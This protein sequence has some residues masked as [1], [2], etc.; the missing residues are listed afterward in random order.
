MS[1]GG[2]FNVITKDSKVSEL[3]EHNNMYVTAEMVQKHLK[4]AFD[5]ISF[6]KL[7]AMSFDEEIYCFAKQSYEKTNL[8]PMRECYS[9]LAIGI[10]I[11]DILVSE[12]TRHPAPLQNLDYFIQNNC[13][14]P[15]D[16]CNQVNI[17][18]KFKDYL[19]ARIDI[20]FKGNEKSDIEITDISDPTA[21]LLRPIRLQRE[22]TCT[23]IESYA[24]SL[25]IRLK[26]KTEGE[27]TIDLKSRFVWGENK[28]TD[29]IPY[30]IDYHLCKI[31]D[32]VEFTEIRPAW[33]DQPICFSRLMTSEEELSLHLEWSP[34]RSDRV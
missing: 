3:L 28:D 10:V 27:L 4:A 23:V 9:T 21:K 34:H 14:Q 20:K 6:R 22:G 8:Y 16:N 11:E 15:V 18:E 32:A 31:N 13:Y 24:G 25:D 1:T 30:W 2:N 29:R 12:N 33:H 17:L 19:T 26:T 5:S 7:F